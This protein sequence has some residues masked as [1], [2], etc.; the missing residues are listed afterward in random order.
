MTVEWIHP[1]LLLILGGWLLPFLKGPLKR[2]GM[3]L[4]PAAALAL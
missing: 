2:A 3:L 4:L 1:G